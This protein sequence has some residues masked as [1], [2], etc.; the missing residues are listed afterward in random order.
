MAKRTH[1]GFELEAMRQ[2]QCTVAGMASR[3]SDGWILYDGH[4]IDCT[5]KGTLDYL[6]TLVDDFLANPGLYP[7]APDDD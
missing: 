1:E 2:D 4:D 3:Q 7:P 5:I 6:E